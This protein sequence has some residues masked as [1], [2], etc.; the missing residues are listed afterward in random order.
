VPGLFDGVNFSVDACSRIIASNTLTSGSP[1]YPS[2]P[3]SNSS[4]LPY[5]PSTNL[6]HVAAKVAAVMSIDLSIDL[7]IGPGSQHPKSSSEGNLLC[8]GEMGAAV[9]PA[10]VIRGGLSHGLV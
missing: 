2:S 9:A 8:W 5:L 3:W 4:R 6:P 1:T 7:S 10:Q